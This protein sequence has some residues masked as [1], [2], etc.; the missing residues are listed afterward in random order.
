MRKQSQRQAKQVIAID[1]AAYNSCWDA[2]VEMDS[3][4]NLKA[5]ERLHQ[6]IVLMTPS[7]KQLVRQRAEL[8]KAEDKSSTIVQDLDQLFA[9]AEG[10]HPYLRCKVQQW[11]AASCGSFQVV[12][13]KERI[14]YPWD[15][16]LSDSALYSKVKWA[17][18]KTRRRAI[19]KMF[20]SYNGDVSRLLDCCRQVVYLHFY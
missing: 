11:A 4:L 12:V 14:F 19:E 1:Q 8:G 7:Q 16:I 15:T 3:Q 20:R 6:L 5:V 18:P 9:M 2:L 17:R 13:G 10:L